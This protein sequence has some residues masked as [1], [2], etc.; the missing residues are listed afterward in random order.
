M[1]F[2]LTVLAVARVTRLITSDYVTERPRNWAVRK[3]LRGRDE[4]MSAYLLLCPWCMSVYV[5]LAG[6]ALWY[7]WGATM[8][9]QAT[10]LALAASHVTG[11]LASREAGD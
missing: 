7:M 5:G 8:W 2:V 10:V 4:S 3:L 6:G 11:A 1:I 9:Y